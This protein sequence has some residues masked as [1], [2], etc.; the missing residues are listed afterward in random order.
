[1]VTFA[2][3]GK[4]IAFSLLALVTRL[5]SLGITFCREFGIIP[6]TLS[7]APV[8]TDGSLFELKCL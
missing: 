6:R 1:M 5:V 4:V 2:V 8:F 7:D 3:D